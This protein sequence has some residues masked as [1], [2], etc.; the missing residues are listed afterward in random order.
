MPRSSHQSFWLRTNL[1][2]C[3][4]HR[5]SDPK[6][7]ATT[8]E[9]KAFDAVDTLLFES[10][11]SPVVGSE[12]EKHQTGNSEGMGMCMCIHVRPKQNH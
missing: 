2:T 3:I 4:G 1:R 8:Y 12:P 10:W 5:C 9:Y 11:T 7:P 6:Y